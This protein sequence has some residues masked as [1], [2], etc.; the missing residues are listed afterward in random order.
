V[1]F[2]HGTETSHCS[3]QC[4]DCD[5]VPV[6]SFPISSS[7]VVIPSELDHRLQDHR[8][9][10]LITNFPASFALVGTSSSYSFPRGGPKRVTKMDIFELVAAVLAR[11]VQI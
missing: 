10:N 11:L 9:Q 6:G 4:T 3:Q 1:V 7:T 2:G 8:L 5:A